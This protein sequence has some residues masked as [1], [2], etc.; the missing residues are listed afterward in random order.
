MLGSNLESHKNKQP[1][2]EMGC[3]LSWN[4]DQIDF[5][6]WEQLHYE[7]GKLSFGGVT[8]GQDVPVPGVLGGPW[9]QT[10]TDRKAR[11]KMSFIL[12]LQHWQREIR[13][14]SLPQTPLQL[15]PGHANS[16]ASIHDSSKPPYADKAARVTL[17][18]PEGKW[19]VRLEDSTLWSKRILWRFIITFLHAFI[20]SFIC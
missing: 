19:P 20:I 9:V 3:G 8:S 18:Q 15:W 1:K 7:V 17:W 2:T 5:S 14:S 10:I 16:L 4:L 13:L 12:Q 6:L 11:T